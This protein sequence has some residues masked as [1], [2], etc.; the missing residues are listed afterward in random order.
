MDQVVESPEVRALRERMGEAAVEG[1]DAAVRD[2]GGRCV[3]GNPGRPK[4]SRNRMTN[5]LA[6]A[7]LDDFTTHEEENLRKLRRWFFTDYVR[8]MGRFLPAH[9][10]QTR[11]DF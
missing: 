5:R 10:K 9:V 6:M 4:G 8:L 7:L 11:P 2:S 3:S 1:R